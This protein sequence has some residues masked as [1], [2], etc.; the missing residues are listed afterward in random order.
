VPKV[1]RRYPEDLARAVAQ[2]QAG[3]GGMGVV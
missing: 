2:L 1:L 3:L